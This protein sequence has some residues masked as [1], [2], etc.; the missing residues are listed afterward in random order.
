MSLSPAPYRGLRRFLRAPALLLF[1]LAVTLAA[2]ARAEQADFSLTLLHTNDVHAHIADFDA[3]GQECTAEKE[4]Q[5]ACLGGAARLATAIAQVRAEGGNALLVDAGDW[6]QGALVYTRFK[7]EAL[8]EVTSRL[9]YQAMAP[10][11]HEF[12]DGPAVLARFIDGVP[13]PLVACNLDASAEPLL[14]GKIAPYA[15]LDVGGRAV[16]V[17]GVANEDTAMLSSP[18]PNV[19]F[20]AAEEPLRAAV[21]ELTGQGVN[22]VVA[23]SHAGFERD[24]ALAAAVAGLDVIVGGHSHLLLANG[25]P[26][27]VGPSPLRIAGPDGDT[28]CVVTAGYWGKYLGRLDVRFD[29]AGRVVEALGAPRPMDA[30]VAK[31]PDMAALVAAYQE[32]LAPFRATAAGRLDTELPLTRADCRGGE[33]LIGDMAAE[34]MLAA[35]ERHEARAA[36]VNAGSIRAGLPAGE[37]TLGAVLTAFPFGNTLVVCDLLGAD[38][39]AALE[40][41]VSL[42]HDPMGSGTGRFP[43]VAGLRYVFDP[44]RETGSRLLAA[45]IRDADGRFAPVDPAAAYRVAISDY[46]ARGGDGYGM[47]KD[48]ARNVM[49]DG[50]AMDEMVA[51]YLAAHAPLALAMD[52][53]I[54][55]AAHP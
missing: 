39:L 15:V 9:G 7:D 42:A 48:R 11:N 2:S 6:F 30:G 8:R 28:A 53:R 34:A 32:R 3:M 4:A 38:L 51:A 50:R 29:A 45:E 33:C 5:G 52:G 10:G 44:S 47:L 16:G 25:A 43:Q 23:V 22:I 27:A 20:T 21:A 13:F 46:L 36:L 37:A 31:D 26:E 55:R 49:L 19:R 41:G 1:V 12:D 24:K 18:G 54:T 14:A 40:H 17:V 35:A